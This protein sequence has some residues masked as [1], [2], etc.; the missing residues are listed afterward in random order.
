MHQCVRRIDEPM[1]ER[2]DADN[3]HSS[4]VVVAVVVS[5]SSI[6]PMYHIPSLFSSMQNYSF[7]FF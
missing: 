4:I 7:V 5:F 1:K 6:S 2:D 3:R